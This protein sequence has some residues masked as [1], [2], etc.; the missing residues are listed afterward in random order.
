MVWTIV[1]VFFFQGMIFVG[2]IFLLRHFMKGN[3]KGE[4][5]HL[6]RLNDELLKRDG[7]LKRRITAAE[8]EYTIRMSKAEQEISTRYLQAKQE[9]T[10]TL[11]DNREQALKEREK[12]IGEAISTREKIRH[13]IMAEM[14]NTAIEYSK[15]VLGE[16]FTGELKKLLHDILMNQLIEAVESFQ[17]ERFQIK[18]DT[19]EFKLAE[20][21]TPELRTKIQKTLKTKIGHEIK[22]KEEVDLSL[23]GG[24]VL[25]F[26]SL[27]IDGSMSNLLKDAAARMKKEAHRKYQSVTQ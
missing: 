22:L 4:L 7:E 8:Q 17:V 16:F 14:E 3:V 23:V 25:Q 24:A 6:D 21:L 13:E 2:L 27:V 12:I 20:S 26:G 10:K 18:T 15:Q 5:G 9:V 1:S 19:A 11:E